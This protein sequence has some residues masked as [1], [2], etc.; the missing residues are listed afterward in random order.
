M[1]SALFDVPYPHIQEWLALVEALSSAR[2]RQNAV[3]D[4]GVGAR[5]G[6]EASVGWFNFCGE[7]MIVE[8]QKKRAKGPDC[9]C[10]YIYCTVH[11]YAQCATTPQLVVVRK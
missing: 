1:F 4:G 6:G 7:C 8:R 5:R 3:S 11:R 9:S 10:S 2:E